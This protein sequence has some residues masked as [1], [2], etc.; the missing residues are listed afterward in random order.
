M[1]SHAADR[2]A[3]VAAPKTVEERLQESE[4]Q[5]RSIFEATSDGL[6]INDFETGLIVE[7]N[8]AF[9]TMHGYTR[10]E[11]I[12][13]HPTAFIHPDSHHLFSAYMQAV[14][15]G[16]PFQATAVD[17][18]KG[19]SLLP[20]EVHGSLFIYQGKPHVLGVVRDI[21]ERVRTEEVLEQR[22]AERTTELVT[23]LA[24]SQN[25]ASVLEVRPL[26]H[27]I[28]DQ[29]KVVADYRGA[30]IFRLEGDEAVVLA[31]RAPGP[32]PEA[33]PG[34]FSLESLRP[35]IDALSPGQPI[36][37]GDVR[38]DSPLA[39]AY[40]ASVGRHLE[41]TFRDERCL[42]AAPMMVQDR[43]IG[44]I[45]LSSDEP[46]CYTTHHAELARGIASYAAIA[47]ENARLYERARE[48]AALEERARL[49]RELHD[50]V[51]QSL[52]S[53]TLYAEAASRLLA[54]GRIEMAQ[55]HLRDVGDTAREALQEMRLL[56]FELRPPVLEQE[57]LAA[58]LRVRLG[59][60]EERAG[61][62]ARLDVD[63]DLELPQAVEETLY[64]VAVEAL[65]NALKHAHARVASV[66]LHGSEDTVTLEV[67][68]DGVGFDPDDRPGAG[69]AGLPGMEERVALIGGR[70]EVQSSPGAGTTIRVEVPR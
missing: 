53:V 2:S 57:G 48:F 61:I 69:G 14:Q 15:E 27:R 65:N 1:T 26:L 60:V 46:G 34:A 17:V 23:V 36:I 6:I 31:R 54:S 49:A 19:G 24:V 47:L 21:T 30:A 40:Q 42:M 66:S 41:T 56:I 50:S 64:R 39:R 38:G 9:C 5:Y 70:F 4:A 25:V 7:V 12:G 20:I 13:I 11:L 63:G 33:G 55:T 35:L 44:V 10:D 62:H 29:L 59:G 45:T 52:Y 28:L 68:D 32:D 22:V 18:C 16:R 3:R 58:A 43:M 8:P 37:I 51:T 67:A